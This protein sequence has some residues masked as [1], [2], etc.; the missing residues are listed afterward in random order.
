MLYL[1]TV[2][3]SLALAQVPTIP[4]PKLTVEPFTFVTADSQRVPA[5]R[6]RIVVPE[7]WERPDGRTIELTFVRLRS[8]SPNPGAPIVYL[9]GG[10]GGSGI[11]TARG[12]RMPVFLRMREVA[13]VIAFDQRGTG[14]SGSLPCPQPVQLPPETPGTPERMLQAFREWSRRCVDH[15]KGQ[16]VDLAAYHTNASADD[17]EALRT[18]LGAEKLSLWSISYGT[19]LAMATMRRYPASIDRVILAGPEPLD[20]M[21]KLPQAT[22]QQLV[23]IDTAVKADSSARALVP[24]LLGLMRT[25]LARLER[26]PA[27]V[28]VT[29]PRTRQPVTLGIDK[30]GVQI[31]TAFQLGDSRGMRRLPAAYLAMSRGDYSGVAP[32]LLGLRAFNTSAM[33]FT[34]DCASGASPRRLAEVRRT[35]PGT[36]LEDAA[37]FPFPEI[38]SEWP[39]E[40][41][42][43]S[44]RA[45]LRS[46]IPTLFIVGTMDGRTPPSNADEI[47]PGLTNSET[48][49]LVGAAH[50]N[51]LFLSSP[52]I[53]RVM[54]AFL[55]GERIPMSEIIL[56]PWKFDFPGGRE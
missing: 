10:P 19:T 52:D 2:A 16:G 36:L 49:T 33:T 50:D 54:A 22:Q 29:D 6:G 30:F 56:P 26:E 11:A 47:R 1:T 53:P 41:L 37:N 14:G 35:A 24:D 44:F 4:T 39:Y 45:P 40:D 12:P 13:D 20:A 21:L 3:L 34:M 48:L 18:A 17:L 46:D 7:R 43:E 38:C 42:G 25:V 9:A 5:E 51:D 15:W 23:R 8:T 31:A 32:V 55:K 28:E 27:R